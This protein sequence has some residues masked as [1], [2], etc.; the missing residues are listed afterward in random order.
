MLDFVV[1]GING[2]FGTQENRNVSADT[3]AA[4]VRVGDRIF[5]DIFRKRI[6]DF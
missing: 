3:Q 5:Q 1:T 6:V 2:L 4:R